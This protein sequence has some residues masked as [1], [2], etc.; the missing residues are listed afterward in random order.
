M[1]KNAKPPL[2]QLLYFCSTDLDQVPTQHLFSPVN[3]KIP[4]YN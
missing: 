2:H 1:L 3:L 4:N